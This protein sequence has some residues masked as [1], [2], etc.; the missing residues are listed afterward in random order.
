MSPSCCFPAPFPWQQQLLLLG[1]LCVVRCFV[2]ILGHQAPSFPPSP[3]FSFD[4][5]G[6]FVVTAA[7]P[8]S[9]SPSTW[10]SHARRLRPCPWAEGCP[11]PCPRSK[12]RWSR[13]TTRTWISRGGG[14]WAVKPRCSWQGDI[15][16]AVQTQPELIQ[17]QYE[18]INTRTG[19][20]DG[21]EPLGAAWAAVLSYWEDTVLGQMLLFTNNVNSPENVSSVCTV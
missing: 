6:R 4:C 21:T 1:K 19:C 2:L 13:T 12:L 7:C 15:E 20:R 8:S 10:R 11:A 3:L 18:A 9:A 5:D 16:R 14:T 17:E